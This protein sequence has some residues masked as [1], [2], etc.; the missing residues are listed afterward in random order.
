MNILSKEG[1]QV[2]NLEMMKVS[3][4]LLI[5]P[6][7]LDILNQIMTD[8]T[9]TNLKIETEEWYRHYIDSRMYN[10]MRTKV[11]A[12]FNVLLRGF[13]GKNKDTGVKN[14]NKNISE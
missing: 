10:F 9:H 13:S 7:D 4:V 6:K 11:L 3:D 14:I 2:S 8:K 12:V 5:K 1:M